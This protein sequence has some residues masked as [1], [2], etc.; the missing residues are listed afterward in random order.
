MDFVE[1]GNKRGV[2]GGYNPQMYSDEG[3]TE[4]YEGGGALAEQGYRQEGQI[5]YERE[6]GHLREDY[7]RQRQSDGYYPQEQKR[8]LEQSSCEDQNVYQHMHQT[9]IYAS[10]NPHEGIDKLHTARYMY[11][12]IKVYIHVL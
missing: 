5:R 2:G 11:I 9:G 8:R 4:R 6:V 10:G 12:Y 1:D 3:Y 7:N